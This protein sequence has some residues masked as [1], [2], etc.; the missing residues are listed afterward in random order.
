[1]PRSPTSVSRCWGRRATKSVAP[2]AAIAASISSSD[3]SGRPKA[4][5]SRTLPLK[6][7]PSWG[8]IPS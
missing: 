5:F 6:R 2:T 1:M 4:T 7:K 3:A 8:T